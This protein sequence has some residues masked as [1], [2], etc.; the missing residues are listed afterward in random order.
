MQ[1]WSGLELGEAV[2]MSEANKR[3]A[4]IVQKKGGRTEGGRAVREPFGLSRGECLRMSGRNKLQEHSVTAGRG[5][6]DED[7]AV[8]SMLCMM[9][10]QNRFS[11]Q[12]R[13]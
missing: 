7:G 4:H 2:E 10:S 6:K 12:G 11:Q 3:N 9:T 1:T 5:V 13:K 8:P